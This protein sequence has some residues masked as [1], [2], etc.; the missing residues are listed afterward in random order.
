MNKRAAKIAD[1]L[2]ALDVEGFKKAKG[3]LAVVIGNHPFIF[4]SVQIHVIHLR[5]G[6]YA[7]EGR[8]MTNKHYRSVLQKFG[9]YIHSDSDKDGN[10]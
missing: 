9:D 5:T 8:Y 7:R 1:A 3:R 10:T 6:E 2:F 4:W